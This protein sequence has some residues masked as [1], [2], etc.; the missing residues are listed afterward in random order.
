M[1]FTEVLT[2]PDGTDCGRHVTVVAESEAAALDELISAYGRETV[3]GNHPVFNQF[4]YEFITK[5]HPNGSLEYHPWLVILELVISK[6]V[7]FKALKE[8]LAILKP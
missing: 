7:G 6:D 5:Y 8:V 1:R 4:K 2:T 3:Y